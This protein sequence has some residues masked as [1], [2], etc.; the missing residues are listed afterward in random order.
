MSAEQKRDRHPA[1]AH[2][3]QFARSHFPFETMSP[4]EYAARRG[5]GW[6]CFSFHLFRYQDEKLDAWIQRLGEIFF[7]PGLM[8]KYQEEF[9]TPDEL[10]RVRQMDPVDF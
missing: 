9:L 1:A 6:L 10:E 8:E 4:E 2:R 3:E 7:T 5:V